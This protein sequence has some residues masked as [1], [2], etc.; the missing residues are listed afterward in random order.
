MPGRGRPKVDKS[1]D[2]DGNREDI[3]A[4]FFAENKSG[5]GNR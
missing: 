3:L 2:F 1:T 4:K 5:G